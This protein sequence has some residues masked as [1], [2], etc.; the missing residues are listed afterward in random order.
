[1][2]RRI[3]IM[4]H[5]RSCHLLNRVW[6]T[7]CLWT[8]R[9]SGWFWLLEN[10][11]WTAKTSSGAF[12]RHLGSA[13]SSWSFDFLSVQHDMW[14]CDTTCYHILMAAH[15]ATFSNGISIIPN[16]EISTGLVLSTLLSLRWVS[17]LLWYWSKVKK[18]S[19]REM[20]I[21]AMEVNI[22]RDSKS[23]LRYRS[24]GWWYWKIWDGKWHI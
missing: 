18:E 16:D 23:Q 2:I 11:T 20:W 1:M 7:V 24:D 22:K 3:I 4:Q 10:F 6:G 13:K 15:M 9:V 5:G 12:S 19:W 21:C 14:H 8:K 17:R